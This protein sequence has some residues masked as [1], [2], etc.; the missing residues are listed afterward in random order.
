MP[1]LPEVQTIVDG[2]NAAGVA[3]HRIDTVSVLWSKTI[4][5]CSPEAFRRRISGRRIL[6][7]YRRAKYI[8]FEL[9]DKLWMLVHLRMTGHLVLVLPSK[10]E[11]PHLQVLLKLD[12]GRCLAY[13]DTRKFGRFFLTA[14]PAAI[15]GALGPEPLAAGFSAKILAQRL[16]RRRRRIKSLLLDQEFLSGLGNIYVDEALWLARVHPL[17][18]ADSLSWQEVRS[19]HRAIR[20]VLRQGIRNAGTSLGNGK[21][22]FISPQSNMGRNRNHLKVF[23]RTG[24]AC[25]RCGRIIERIVVGQRSTHICS[26]CQV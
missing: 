21:G 16:W 22:N 24:Q 23:Q 15:L 18:E 17:R 12:D 8:V 5:T 4:A 6:R 1:E 9:S 3:G 25:L 19:L 26:K 11:K 13:H 2:L 10:R 7:I 14:E 20:R